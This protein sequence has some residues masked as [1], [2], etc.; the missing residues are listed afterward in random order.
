MSNIIIRPSWGLPEAEVTSREGYVNRR[1]FVRTLGLG[2]VAIAT[3]GATGAAA[4]SNEAASR[5]MANVPEGPLDTIPSNAT[6]DGYPASRNARFKVPERAVTDR[7]TAS[8]YNNF[9]EFDGSSKQ[10]WPLTGAYEPFPWTIEVGG[11]VDKPLKLDVDELIRTM[12]LE[13]RVYRFRCVE[14]WSMTIP[15]TGFPLAKLVERCKPL[16]TAT[17]VR[18]V[19]AKRDDQM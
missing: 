10:V 8:S 6:R 2:A 4:C 5:A 16:S 9:Y 18:F 11:L 15:W 3:T 14:A 7:I 17:H 13:E 12:S 19:S 1:E